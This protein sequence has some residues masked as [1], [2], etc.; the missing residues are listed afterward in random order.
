MVVVVLYVVMGVYTHMYV[1]CGGANHY[2]RTRNI[3]CLD[4]HG[5]DSPSLNS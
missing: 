3:A 1:R 2:S 4:S 5:A